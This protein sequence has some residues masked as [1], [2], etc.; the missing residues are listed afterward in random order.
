VLAGVQP[1]L[2]DDR[3][4]RSPLIVEGLERRL[5]GVGVA[6]GVD[7]L[8]VTRDLLALPPGR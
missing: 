4:A 1:G 8:Q 3:E 2:G 5:R 6:G 7:R